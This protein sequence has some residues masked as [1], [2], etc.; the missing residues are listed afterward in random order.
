MIRNEYQA[1]LDLRANKFFQ[2]LGDLHQEGV[3]GAEFIQRM[4]SKREKIVDKATLFTLGRKLIIC[5]R[6][7]S[8]WDE[9]LHQL[10]K[11]HKGLFR[12]MFG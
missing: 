4:A 1:E 11:D 7:V 2:T 5:S 9:E 10:V 8:W 12:S 3:V 6:S